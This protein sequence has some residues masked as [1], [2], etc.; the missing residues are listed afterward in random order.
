MRLNDQGILKMQ[1]KEV[2]NKLAILPQSSIALEGVTMEQL[3]K[4]GRY[5]YQS[6]L[7]Q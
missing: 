3:V 7:K 6:T 1:S 2:A 5:P 4:R